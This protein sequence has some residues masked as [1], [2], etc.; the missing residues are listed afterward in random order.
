MNRTLLS[1]SAVATLAIGATTMTAQAASASGSALHVNAGHIQNVGWDGDR[2]WD[3]DRR[4]RR[5]RS[6]GRRGVLAPQMAVVA[7]PPQGQP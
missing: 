7:P 3:D 6:L 2:G 1:L 4:W 5:H